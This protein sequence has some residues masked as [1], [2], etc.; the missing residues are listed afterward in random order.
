ML[1]RRG[2]TA[3]LVLTVVVVAA[4]SCASEGDEPFREDVVLCEEALAHVR[5]C[6]PGFDGTRLECTFRAEHGC[7]SFA[8]IAFSKS[9]SNCIR[10]TSCEDIVRMGICSRAQEAHTWVD[11]SVPVPASEIG[12][13]RRPAV[14]P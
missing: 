14:C 1:R 7:G 5:T 13:A 11:A 4:L 3:A 12:V 9:E 2:P 8:R 6:C 10:D